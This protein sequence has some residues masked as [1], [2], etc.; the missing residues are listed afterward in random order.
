MVRSSLHNVC[1]STFRIDLCGLRGST[2]PIESAST[3]ATPFVWL[4]LLDSTAL[5]SVHSLSLL[6]L[7]VFVS[8]S[9][10]LVCVAP[11]FLRRL[12]GSTFPTDYVWLCPVYIVYVALH[13]LL[14][15]VVLLSLLVCVTT[16][17]TG[18]CGST[19][20]TKSVALPSLH[21]LWL[22]LPYW[23][24]WVY[25][26]YIICVA[27][28]VLLVCLCSSTFPYSRHRWDKLILFSFLLRWAVNRGR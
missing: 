4:Y 12:C 10:L 13:S 7:S 3:F 11:P 20:P 5:P 2:F 14:A 17:P 6:F 21:S 19:F 15:S 23:S 9:S 26:P 24:V 27:L 25:L 8:L 18:L 22:C 16:F 1:G 28:H